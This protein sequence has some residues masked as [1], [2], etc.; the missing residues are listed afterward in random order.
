MGFYWRRSLC[1]ARWRRFGWYTRG[2]RCGYRPRRFAFAFSIR[3]GY[4]T[5]GLLFYRLHG[6]LN[7][8]SRCAQLSFWR[9][10]W[11]VPSE[12]RE[13]RPRRTLGRNPTVI[14]HR[15]HP[16]TP[17]WGRRGFSGLRRGSWLTRSR[18]FASLYLGNNA[19]AV[20]QPLLCLVSSS[21]YRIFFE[22][23]FSG[24]V[25]CPSQI[26]CQLVRCSLTL[27]L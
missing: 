7:A 11:V 13:R 27:G 6:R 16:R 24:A 9:A 4:L 20:I 15:V 8:G 26:Y 18:G 1:D 17:R 12:A 10:R 14:P 23:P 5:C 25:F 21:R 19:F 22:L 2:S 3:F